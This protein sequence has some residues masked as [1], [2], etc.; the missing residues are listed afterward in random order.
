MKQLGIIRDG[1]WIYTFN[2]DNEVL[3]KVREDKTPIRKQILLLTAKE[4]M[5]TF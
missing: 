3:T 1:K 2:E 4:V 5:L